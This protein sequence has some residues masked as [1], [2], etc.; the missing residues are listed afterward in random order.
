M[1][2]NRLEIGVSAGLVA[3]MIILVLMVSIVAPAGFKSAGYSLVVLLF[4]VLMGFAGIKL[5]DIQ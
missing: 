5:I 4:M 3:L 2:K 1:K